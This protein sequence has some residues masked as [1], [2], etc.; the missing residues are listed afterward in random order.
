[1]GL[2]LISHDLQ[3][4]ARYCDRVLVMYRGRIVDASPATQLANSHH[5]YT[6]MLWSCKPSAATYGTQL[7]VLKGWDSAG[8]NA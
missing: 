7:P 4:V 3:Q 1:M 2:L 8:G 6:R 5:P